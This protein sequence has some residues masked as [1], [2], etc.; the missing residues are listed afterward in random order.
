MLDGKRDPGSF[1]RLCWCVFVIVGLAA[2]PQALMSEDGIANSISF[3]KP[4]TSD[5][6]A[7]NSADAKKLKFLLKH[8]LSKTYYVKPG[9]SI[10]Q[11]IRANYYLSTKAQPHAYQLYVTAILDRNPHLS[12]DSVLQPKQTLR[13]PVGPKY[14]ALELSPGVLSSWTYAQSPGKAIYERHALE[15]MG[16]TR[17]LPRSQVMGRLEAIIGFKVES[18]TGEALEAAHVVPPLDSSQ[19]TPIE[20]SLNYETVP[21]LTTAEESVEVGAIPVFLPA[22]LDLDSNVDCKS[23]CQSCAQLLNNRKLPGDSLVRVLVADSGIDP[24]IVPNKPFLYP[25]NAPSDEATN[26]HGTFVYS[27][28]S[29]ASPLGVISDSQLFVSSVVGIKPGDSDI[30]WKLDAFPEVV[31]AFAEQRH[32]LQA[33]V[34]NTSIPAWIVNVSASGLAPPDIPVPPFLGGGLSGSGAM[35]LFVAAAGNN[36]GDDQLLKTILFAMENNPS[37]LI[38]GAVDENGKVASYSNHGTSKVDVFERGSCVCGFGAT[39]D[40]AGY[41]A[42]S[43]QLSGT[44]QA[45]PVVSAAAAIVADAHPRW[46]ASDVK[47][48]LVSTANPDGEFGAQSIGGV[49]DIEAALKSS[50]QLTT[51]INGTNC[52]THQASQISFGVPSFWRVAIPDDVSSRTLLRVHRKSCATPLPAMSCFRVIDK[53]D[54]FLLSVAERNDSILTYIENGQLRTTTIGD[55][56]DLVLPVYQKPEEN[57]FIS[58]AEVYQQ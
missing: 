40:A 50:F 26:K 55:L 51:C 23:R 35:L 11:I 28:I 14:G 27:E 45:A 56:Q 12:L 36:G 41:H 53:E 42:G 58:D 37:L 48:R 44:S 57:G 54:D 31:K 39:P 49:V 17:P 38:V 15:S 13:I 2:L 52:H 46:T 3:W 21:L 10:D 22:S 7:A 29:S 16:T 9:D 32:Q 25:S 33:N 18:Q 1:P 8:T 6:S 34:T 20:Q 5:L 24:N 30:S 19:V 43:N 4:R 47:S